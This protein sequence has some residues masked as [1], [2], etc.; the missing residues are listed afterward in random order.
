MTATARQIAP[1]WPERA[2]FGG[3]DTAPARPTFRVDPALQGLEG[4][5]RVREAL[6]AGEPYALA[7]VDMR[8]PPGLNGL[9]TAE[10]LW[11]VEADLQ[12]V[13]CSAFRMKIG[14][15]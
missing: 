2:L 3:I 14:S 15:M 1:S 5:Q 12:I 7:F 13:L 4:L 9:E 10:A 8:M 11:R 6:E